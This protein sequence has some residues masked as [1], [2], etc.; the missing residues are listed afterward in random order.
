MLAKLDDH[1]H[2]WLG[3]SQDVAPDQYAIYNGFREIM[4][5]GPFVDEEP[6]YQWWRQL[7]SIPAVTGVLLRQQSRRR[8]KPKSLVIL[9]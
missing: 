6:E 7:P 2:G 3:G 4:G 8:W 9:I 5:E 1:Q